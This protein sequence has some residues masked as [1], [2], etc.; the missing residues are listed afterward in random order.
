MFSR[1]ALAL[2]AF[3]TTLVLIPAASGAA[4]QPPIR[5]GIVYS[6]TGSSPTAGPALDASIAAW[7][8]MHHQLVG[9]RKVTIIRRD[10]TG[11][12]PDVA[13]RQ[14]QE[15]IVAE[16]V[17]FLMGSIFTPDAIAIMRVSTAARVPFFIVNAATN[18][19]IAKAPYTFRFG[20]TIQQNT[21][22]LAIWAAKNG[23]K[24]VFNIVSDYA[25]GI[26]SD[27]VFSSAFTAGGGKVLGDL[28][29]PIKAGDFTGYI[30]R[31]KDAKPQAN[32]AFVIAGS[33]SLAFFK[34]SKLAELE[35]AGIKTIVNGATVD[36]LDLD[37]IG[38]YALGV[39]SCAQYSWTHK[40]RLNEQYLAAY[41]RA[42]TNGVKN[43]DFMAEG[44]YD[45]MSAIDRVVAAQGGAHSGTLDLDKTLATLKGLKL[46][47]P[48][49]PIQIDAKTRELIQNIYIRKV[50]RVNGVLANVEFETF[51][52]I[53][54]DYP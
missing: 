4:D 37:A 40:S 39:V 2:A 11:P 30:Q 6:Y 13:A 48:R 3:I 53:P 5:I 23:I 52:Q 10:D 47:S 22:P 29:V 33:P 19:I 27:K 28:H 17:D 51:P 26:E 8:A 9:G 41:R 45:I 25:P 38:D 20:A 14:A 36:D 50:Q 35:S 15:L 7:L 44:G 46:D 31:V 43:P 18:G 42:A 32:F 16:H 54:G 1:I 34:A 49:G 24:T 12:A 21:V